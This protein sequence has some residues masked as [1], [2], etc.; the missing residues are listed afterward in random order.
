MTKAITTV[1]GSA[2]EARGRD[3]HAAVELLMGP[4]SPTRETVVGQELPGHEFAWRRCP[5]SNV[6]TGGLYRLRRWSS[7]F[8]LEM[9]ATTSMSSFR[10][11][12]SSLSPRRIA[13]TAP[14]GMRTIPCAGC[15]GWR[16]Q[17]E[18]KHRLLRSLDSRGVVCHG[19]RLCGA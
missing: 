3:V 17:E 7:P 8:P 18:S 2:D 14:R 10:S 6:S 16:L 11:R 9:R 4:A 1:L 5:G 12:R 15:L 19:A 13:M